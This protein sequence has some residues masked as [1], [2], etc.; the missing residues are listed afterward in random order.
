M[1][2]AVLMVPQGGG[3]HVVQSLYSGVQ[4]DYKATNSLGG[5]N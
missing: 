4:G 3:N 1:N 2:V 5:Q